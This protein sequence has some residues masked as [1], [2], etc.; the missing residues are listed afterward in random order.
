MGG[1]CKGIGNHSDKVTS[2][3]QGKDHIDKRKVGIPFLSKLVSN[4]PFD[5]GIL[6]LHT[7]L[8]VGRNKLSS[9]S[10]KGVNIGTQKQ[11]QPQNGHEEGVCDGKIEPSNPK[12]EKSNDGELFQRTE[13][14]K[15]VQ[16]E[17]QNRTFTKAKEK[18]SFQET[19]QSVTI[20]PVADRKPK[21]RSS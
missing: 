19:G 4:Q 2:Q 18:E 8:G 17:H 16:D 21:E 1:R 12:G 14:H 11:T 13:N 9:C 20:K 7:D 15:C 3:N 5:K 6:R 10:L